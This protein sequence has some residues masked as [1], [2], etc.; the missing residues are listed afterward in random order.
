[1]ELIE[2]QTVN[3]E[4]HQ[5]SC[6]CEVCRRTVSKPLRVEQSDLSAPNSMHDF[7]RGLPT[8]FPLHVEQTLLCHRR[9]DNSSEYHSYFNPSRDDRKVPSL[10]PRNLQSLTSSCAD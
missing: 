8:H 1:M 7:L 10:T 6:H 4:I 2:L 5:E 9:E 3:E